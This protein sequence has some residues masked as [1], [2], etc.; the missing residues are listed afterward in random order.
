[1]KVTT[2]VFKEGG[3]QWAEACTTTDNWLSALTVKQEGD[4]PQR[5]RGAD[6]LSHVITCLNEAEEE[7]KNMPG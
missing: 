4:R 3:V 7:K 2:V 6:M 5:E 1:M